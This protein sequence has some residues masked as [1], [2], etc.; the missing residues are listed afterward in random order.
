MKGLNGKG[1]FGKLM[2]EA[3]E[4]HRHYTQPNQ[5]K[6]TDTDTHRTKQTP[7]QWAERTLRARWIQQLADN[8]RY[9][10][11]P[12]TRTSWKDIQKQNENDDANCQT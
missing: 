8:R 2:Q 11:H 6:H 12:R 10:T 1:A 5:S 7:S 3:V 9:R 4:R